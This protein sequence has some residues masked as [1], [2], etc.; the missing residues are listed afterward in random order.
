MQ[1]IK[2]LG[3][4]KGKKNK[5]NLLF[6]VGDRLLKTVGKAFQKDKDLTSILKGH[7]DEHVELLKKMQAFLKLQQKSNLMLLRE[8]AMLESERLNKEKPKYTI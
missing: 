3:V 6:L 2:L 5:V 4:E 7:P 1:A 8:L